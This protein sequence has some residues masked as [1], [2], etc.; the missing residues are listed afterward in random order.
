MP[1]E[2]EPATRWTAAQTRAQFAAIANLRWRMSINAYRRKGGAGELV[3][4]IILFTFFAGFAFGMMALAGSMAFLAAWKDHLNRLD[5]LLLGTF[6]LCQF[7]NIQLGQPGTTF[8]PTQLIRFPM[9]VGNYVAVR[10]F[11]GLLTPANIIGA[12]ISLAIAAGMTIAI[13]SLWFY[14]L[15]ALAVFA[16]ANALFSRMV[17]AWVDRWLSTRRAREVFT[18]FI[19]TISI[20]IQYLNVAFNP[21]Y[22]HH[23]KTSVPS[24]RITAALHLYHR[25]HPFLGPLPPGLIASALL[26]A[27][28]DHIAAFFAFTLGC[29]I[30]AALF[31]AVFAWRTSIEFRGENLSD[32]ANAVS[33]KPKPVPLPSPARATVNTQTQPSTL[34]LPPAVAAV[35]AKEFLQVRRNTGVFFGLIAPVA[36]VFIFAGKLATRSNA[37]WVFPA[38]LAYTLMAIGPLAYNSFGLEG[39]GSQFYFMAPVRLRDVF[40]AKN[41]I[42]FALAIIEV[43][44]VFAIISYVAVPPSPAMVV[45]AILWASATLLLSTTI[46]NRRSVTA[47]KKI[48]LGRTSS[49]QASQARALISMGVLL[50]S[51]A[52]GA[53]SLL[54]ATYLH[55]MW[56]LLPVFLAL[57]AGALLIYR[58]GLRSIDRFTLDHREELFEELCKK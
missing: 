21:A 56:I 45:A 15:L 1:N 20:G 46:G 47:P 48:D 44:A 53:A 58:N 7:M 31:F 16:I 4:R 12:L 6:L 3:G 51:A 57:A 22:N 50:G 40:L 2:L 5:L 26:A 32:V 17:F 55:A 30:F 25:A 49:K 35:L 34:S 54:L 28:Q 42:N 38:A 43:A 29:M 23:H 11:F 41:L 33:T 39:A 8:D 18:A 13:P 14:A 24:E 27:H 19:F 36:F 37:S 10:L 52:L 9:R